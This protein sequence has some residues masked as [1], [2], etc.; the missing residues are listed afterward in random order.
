M[1]LCALTLKLPDKLQ[2]YGLYVYYV[3]HICDFGM[4]RVKIIKLVGKYKIWWQHNNKWSHSNCYFF[5]FYTLSLMGLMI[6]PITAQWSPYLLP[7]EHN[8]FHHKVT[9]WTRTSFIA[10]LLAEHKQVSSQRW[11]AV[12]GLCPDSMFPF[13]GSSFCFISCSFLKGDE[14]RGLQIIQCIENVFKNHVD[15]R[16][17]SLWCN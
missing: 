9:S 13:G 16:G 6:D 17:S 1:Y 4:L 14:Q 5:C 2:P 7:A 10:K 8:K 3:V 12:R 11:Q 15:W